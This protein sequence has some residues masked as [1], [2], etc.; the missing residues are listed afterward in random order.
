LGEPARFSL[1]V[2]YYEVDAYGHV[3]HAHYVHYLEVARIEA[4]EG[5]GLS[6]AELRRAGHF[7]VATDLSVKYHSPAHPSDM[8]DIVTYVREMRGARSVWVQEIREATSGRLVLTA[9]VTGA[10]TTENGRPLRAS[11]A[12]RERLAQL[13]VPDAA[14]PTSG[15]EDSRVDDLIR[16]AIG[17][18]AGHQHGP[19]ESSTTRPWCIC[20]GGDLAKTARQKARGIRRSPPSPL[21]R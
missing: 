11:A 3:N 17:R 21:G 2:R 19:L 1:K 7:I 10:F 16:A 4:L 8:L 15:A 6:L 13:W 5:V 14:L 20:R 9:Q 12:T 18:H